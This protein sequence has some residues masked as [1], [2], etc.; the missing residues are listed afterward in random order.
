MYTHPCDTLSRA[1]DL[2]RCASLPG[3]TSCAVGAPH[4]CARSALVSV[5]LCSLS[6]RFALCGNAGS[7][8]FLLDLGR[9]GVGR[10]PS[11]D[12]RAKLWAWLRWCCAYALAFRSPPWQPA[13]SRIAATL[14]SHAG[15]HH[16]SRHRTLAPLCMAE[17][18]KAEP[19]TPT[20]LPHPS[21]PPT[22]PSLRLVKRGKERARC[23]LRLLLA[24]GKLPARV[25]EDHA[26]LV[27]LR[28]NLVPA[29]RVVERQAVRDHV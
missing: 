29:G 22:P 1:I 16:S 20:P 24:R 5:R 19:P 25:E 10:D 6:S 17:A 8:C 3:A 26:A 7:L 4:A 11:S 9:L 2:R 27:R 18:T 13:I 12:S 28:R 21:T 14:G 23:S 15:Q